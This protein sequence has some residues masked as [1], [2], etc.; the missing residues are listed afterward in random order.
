M[1]SNIPQ[2][3]EMCEPALRFLRN[4]AKRDHGRPI[5][6][7]EILLDLQHEFRLSDEEAAEEYPSGNGIIFQ[8][9]LTFAMSELF[10]EG[11]VLR[12]RRGYY[13]PVHP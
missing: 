4:K 6:Y 2:A 5:H 1:H 3:K 12:P 7:T 11:L 8:N 10:K 13:L 9:R